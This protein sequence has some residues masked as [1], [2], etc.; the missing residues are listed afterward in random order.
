[1]A[2]ILKGDV[3]WASLDPVRG[4]EQGGKRPVLVVSN[5]VLNEKSGT[6]IAMAIT[7]QKPRVGFPLAMAIRSLKMPK[8]SWIKLNQVRTV[9]TKRLGK[10]LGRL[11]AEEML[12]VIEGLG[13]LVS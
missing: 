11:S 13:E 7:S 8:P 9:S 3:F 6:V 1:M 10:K 2:R 12:D 4:H 5:D